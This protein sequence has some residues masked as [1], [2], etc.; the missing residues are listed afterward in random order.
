MLQYSQVAL[1][2][3]YFRVQY[4]FISL[5]K[6]I[7]YFYLTIKKLQKI[8]NTFLPRRSLSLR[9]VIDGNEYVQSSIDYKNKTK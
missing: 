6:R 8:Y 2:K 3:Q 5:A 7:N 1:I 4:K 9:G